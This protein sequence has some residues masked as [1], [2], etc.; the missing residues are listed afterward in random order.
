[1]SV[2]GCVGVSVQ[3]VH[4]KCILVSVGFIR[5]TENW[6]F[7]IDC[8]LG[9]IG[10]SNPTFRTT[11][12][13]LTIYWSEGGGNE[14]KKKFSVNEYICRIRNNVT[15]LINK[16]SGYLMDKVSFQHLMKK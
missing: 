10:G 11:N 2:G 15:V 13:L 16:S 9:F 1:M 4:E 8:L 12:C 6:G 3:G 14:V 5:F 7:R